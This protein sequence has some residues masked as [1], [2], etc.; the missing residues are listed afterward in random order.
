MRIQDAARCAG[1]MVPAKLEITTL[2]IV[3]PSESAKT[4][5]DVTRIAS[6]EAHKRWLDVARTPLLVSAHS[7]PR[8][9]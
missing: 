8:V 9:D 2:R 6:M 3:D 5:D 1:P 4:D 7:P